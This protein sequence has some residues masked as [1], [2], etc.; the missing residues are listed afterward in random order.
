[1]QPL[2]IFLP[3]AC[4]NRAAPPFFSLSIISVFTPK[5]ESAGPVI[6]RSYIPQA[7]FSIWLIRRLHMGVRSNR[8][9]TLPSKIK[10]ERP[11]FRWLPRRE[12]STII[13]LAPSAQAFCISSSAAIN[14]L[15]AATRS[16]VDPAQKIYNRNRGVAEVRKE[17]YPLPAASPSKFAGAQHKVVFIKHT[18]RRFSSHR[19][20]SARYNVRPQAKSISRFQA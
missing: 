5:Q 13:I 14:G 1:M 6:P 15:E 18:I 19:V 16:R 4:S 17:Q 9:E 12:K 11:F 3:S 2:S 10:P 20:V 8:A 7:V